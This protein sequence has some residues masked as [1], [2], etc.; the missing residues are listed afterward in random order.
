MKNQHVF[1]SNRAI[2]LR[3]MIAGL[4][5][6]MCMMFA[7]VFSSPEVQAQTCPGDA[8]PCN[9]V[10]IE[11]CTP[12][13]VNFIIIYCDGNGTLIT[14]PVMTI[15]A[16]KCDPATPF[17]INGQIVRVQPA[18]PFIPTHFQFNPNSCMLHLSM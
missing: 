16:N 18:G 10:H 9:T 5:A 8:S 4:S 14:S 13:D 17:Q 7:F 11:N 2:A 3:N 12:F 15:D 6:T 1:H